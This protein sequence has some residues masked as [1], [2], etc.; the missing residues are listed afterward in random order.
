MKLYKV[1]VGILSTAAQTALA[2]T[3][4]GAGTSAAVASTAANAAG[5]YGIDWIAPTAFGKAAKWAFARM[6]KLGLNP[7]AG[8]KLQARLE[9]A[10]V[11]R[12]AFMLNRTRQ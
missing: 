3:T 2:M 9:A 7:A 10:G 12:N 11:T 5:L 1:G 8:N 6:G 4:T